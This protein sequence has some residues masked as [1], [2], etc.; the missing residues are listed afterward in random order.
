M[1][2]SKLF[3]KT[4]KK[5]SGQV[6]ARSHEL[7][8]RAGYIDQVASGIFT[9]LPL[10]K[11]V[12]DKISN[13]VRV[14]M[15]NIDGQEISMPVLHPKKNWMI[16]G[17]YD[18]FDV[19][20][21]ITSQ[22]KNEYVIAPSHE[23]IVNPLVA[24]NLQSFRDLPIYLYHISQK[25][26]DEPRPKSGILRGREFTM[27]DLYS[28]HADQK[29]LDTYYKTVMQAYLKIYSRCGL[30]NIKITE[31]SGG[32]FSK[33]N[34]HEFNVLTKYGEVMLFYCDKCNFA[35]NEEVAQVKID[36]Q[37]PICKTGTIKEGKAIEVGNIFDCA[38]KYSRAFNIKYTDNQ[39]VEKYPLMGCYGIGISRMLGTIVEVN[40]DSAGIIWPQSV[41]PFKAHLIDLTKGEN[42]SAQKIYESL[43]DAQIDVLFDNR[44]NTPA[45]EKFADCDL[46]GIPIRLVVS[47][48]TAGNIEYKS[49]SEKNMEIV[50][51][52]QIINRLSK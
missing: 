15:N 47:E 23:E 40:N 26:R 8:V 41:A 27:K 31:A 48:K 3:G 20:F 17:R 30:Q 12:L 28:F 42:D 25:F 24:K 7:L 21:K 45:G 32:S 36:E 5:I 51:L 19:L 33:K 6:E 11:K 14:E 44:S 43:T 18:S 52:Q 34:S 1:K 35:Q 29:D 13:I 4:S 39:G 50:N 37:C 2:Y 10:G 38:D 46:I 22:S 49:R 16:T 9:I